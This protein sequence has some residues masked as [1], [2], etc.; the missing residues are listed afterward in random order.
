[1]MLRHPE[2]MIAPLLGL[3]RQFDGATQGVHPVILMPRPVIPAKAGIRAM[4]RA[5]VEDAQLQGGHRL[6]EIS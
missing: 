6:R 4:N 3:P 2:T 5:L 1:M